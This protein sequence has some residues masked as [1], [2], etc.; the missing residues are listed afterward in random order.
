L[1]IAPL[2]RTAV[3]SGAELDEDFDAKLHQFPSSTQL[4]AK[5]F[6]HLNNAWRASIS[7]DN[8]NN[9]I[10]LPQSGLPG[11]GRTLRV[12]LAYSGF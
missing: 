8:W 1:A 3:Y 4:N 2:R 9:D 10:V 5:L 6:Y 12:G 7:I 11:Q